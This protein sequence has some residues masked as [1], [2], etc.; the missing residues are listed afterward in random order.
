L[1]R[2]CKEINDSDDAI[3]TLDGARLE[4]RVRTPSGGRGLT[5]D[6]VILDE[7]LELNA[8]QIAALVPVLL[9]RPWAQLWYFSTVPLT[10]DQ[11]LCTVRQRAMDGDERLGWAEWGVDRGVALDDPEA[12]AQANPAL[13]VRITLERLKDL[14][15]ILGDVKYSAE[16]M[17]IWPDMAVGTALDPV[18]WR[19]VM[20]DLDSRRAP[21]ADVV[22]SLDI[23]PM[24]DH[25]SIGMH[26]L[27]GDGL[28]HV[29]LTDYE[30]GTDWMVERVGE[31][32]A[33]LDPALWVL[34]GKNG[35]FAL[36]DDLAAVGIKV[37]T[38]P[39]ALNRGELLVLTPAEVSDSVA[40]FID[41]FRRRPPPLRHP[42]QT[43]LN[44]AIGNA[45][46]RTIGDAGQIAWGRKLSTVDIGPVVVVTQARY[47]SHAWQT[48]RA[49]AM[50]R[51]RVW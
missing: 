32:H 16:C 2:R 46:P 10:A 20:L 44:T 9:A 11:Y 39:Q 25:G 12:L 28:E 51:S 21:G 42:G 26:G 37:A 36:V 7:A 13:G 47:G 31:L 22:L 23:T 38:D 49:R 40:Q 19:T 35:V 24:R 43:P 8:E 29:Q 3:Q 27:R 14:R 48:R 6:L 17:G 45:R 1:K 34:D 15:K 50:P 5:G 4:F 18:A 33:T 30:A 41:A